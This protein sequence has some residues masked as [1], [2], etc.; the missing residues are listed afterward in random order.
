MSRSLE[1]FE[2]G[3]NWQRYNDK[4]L[5]PDRVEIAARSLNDLIGEDL[6]GKVF[7][8]IGAGS[9]LFSLCAYRAGA[10]RVISLDV[11]PESVEACRMLRR[12]IGNPNSW[13][14]CEGSILDPRFI[15]TLPSGDVVYSWG[16]LHHT[17]DMYRALRNAAKLVVPGGVLCIGIYNRVSGR[18]LDS[19]RWRSIKRRY[20]QAPRPI[21]R[22][23]EA[24][25]LSVW[26]ARQ[27]YR[28]RNPFTAAA[29]YKR[30]RGMA[31]MT[32][33]IDWLGG[34]PYEYATPD[35]IVS[36]CRAEC[37]LEEVKVIRTAERSTGNN[38]FVF[39]LAHPH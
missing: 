16:V 27:L 26:T 32:D 4:Y 12:S 29:Q 3:R 17:G 9:G 36:F 1:A 30:S 11:D 24:A 21:Q 5:D 7:I 20:N 18:V 6:A 25:Y 15:L 19:K 31:L 22:T 2:F 34:Y 23:M 28:R 14:I 33:V 35:E 37:G 13:E 39:R 10:A 38:Q 8:D